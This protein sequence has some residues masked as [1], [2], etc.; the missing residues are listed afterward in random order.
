MEKIKVEIYTD[1]ACLGNPGP[2]GF[3]VVF[4]LNG[5]KLTGS[6]GAAK[7]TNNA[8]EL[9]GAIYALENLPDREDLDITLY[10]DSTYVVNGYRLGWIDNWKRNGWRTS[11]GKPVKNME[12]W[13]RLDV[14][15][16]RFNAKFVWV[17]GHAGNADNEECD[18]LAKSAAESFRGRIA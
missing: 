15:Q 9:M 4:R 16:A 8:M 14:L 17:E 10:S 18:R 6:G 12:L 7:T 2:G 3:G 5:Q 11:A 1:G 13:K